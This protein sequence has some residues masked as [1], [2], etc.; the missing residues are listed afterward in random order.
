MMNYN[1]IK[2]NENNNTSLNVVDIENEVNNILR[3]LTFK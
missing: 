3:D 2:I 1:K